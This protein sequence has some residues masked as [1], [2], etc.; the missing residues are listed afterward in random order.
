MY[1]FSCMFM[2]IYSFMYMYI[3]SFRYVYIY[4]YCTLKS[5]VALIVLDTVIVGLHPIFFKFG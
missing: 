4:F 5:G 2:Y 3:P 1:I